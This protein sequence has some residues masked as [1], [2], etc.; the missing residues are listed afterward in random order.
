M[1]FR[2][3]GLNAQVTDFTAQIETLNSQIS[4]LNTQI[5]EF[6]AKIAEH[7]AS[8]ATL[9]TENETLN[10]SLNAANETIGNKEGELTTAYSTITTLT[11]ERDALVAYK[12]EVIKQQKTAIVTSYTAQLPEEVIEEFLN[13]L[14]NY[15]LEQLDM[16]L[17]YEQ[18]K[19]NPALFAKQAVETPNVYIPKDDGGAAKGISDILA[20]YQK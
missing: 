8:I 18:K 5:S 14:D 6:V 15:S 20:K 13:N 16:V 1:L 12:N 7:E 11:S 2:S 17:T 3:G 10:A 19:H 9:N 4:D